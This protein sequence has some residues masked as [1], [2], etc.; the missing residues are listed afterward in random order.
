MF[1]VRRHIEEPE[2]FHRTRD[3]AAQ[4]GWGHLISVLKPP[5]LWTT[6]KVSLMVSGAQRGEYALSVWLPTYLKNVRHLSAPSTGGFLII[7]IVSA[8]IGFLIG[9]YL[10]DAIGRKSTFMVSAIGSLIMVLVYMFAPLTVFGLLLVNV[11]LGILL[12]IKFPPM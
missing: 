2:L 7:L 4:A 5:Y 12:Y 1:W 11:P 6:V 9:A 8:L 3:A 10:S